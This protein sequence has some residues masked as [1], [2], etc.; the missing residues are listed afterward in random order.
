MALE[1]EQ[2]ISR[3]ELEGVTG[4]AA[5]GTPLLTLALGRHQLPDRAPAAR[6]QRWTAGAMPST[7]GEVAID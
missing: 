1:I 6:T 7:P 5:D 4:A 2:F 3:R